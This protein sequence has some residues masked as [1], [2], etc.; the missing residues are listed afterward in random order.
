MTTKKKTAKKPKAKK[1]AWFKNGAGEP[2]ISLPGGVQAGVYQDLFG[3]WTAFAQVGVSRSAYSREYDSPKAAKAAAL[4][5]AKLVKRW[6]R[7]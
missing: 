1:A 4:D 5:L 7:K 3:G 6:G 2:R